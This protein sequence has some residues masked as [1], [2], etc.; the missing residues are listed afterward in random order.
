LPHVNFTFLFPPF[1]LEPLLSDLSLRRIIFSTIWRLSSVP[2]V[3]FPSSIHFFLFRISS[4][5]MSNYFS[6]A[7]QKTT[8]PPCNPVL[9]LLLSLPIYRL[10][11]RLY[12]LRGIRPLEY[13]FSLCSQPRRCMLLCS[14]FP[15][16]FICATRW[17]CSSKVILIPDF[18]DLVP[19][20]SID[21]PVSPRSFDPLRHV[22]FCVPPCLPVVILQPSWLD[23]VAK[24][25]PFHSIRCIRMTKDFPY[26]PPIK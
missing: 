25:S 17:K 15:L 20:C 8:L 13:P 11:E 1:P 10:I 12:T 24:A 23:L 18:C 5:G 3:H 4:P 21:A 19:L 22:G 6:R 9:P 26:P 16:L 2:T 14:F 7:Y